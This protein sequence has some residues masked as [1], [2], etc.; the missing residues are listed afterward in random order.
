MEQK[1]NHPE[2]VEVWI[3]YFFKWGIPPRER[4]VSLSWNEF[5]QLTL[6]KPCSFPVR[7]I[8][9]VERV[10]S[11]RFDGTVFPDKVNA[12]LA[13]KLVGIEVDVLPKYIHVIR[14]K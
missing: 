3:S 6:G 5:D 1:H 11:Q 4:I 2:T 12:D 8:S 10:R 13:R 9:D 14:L 7:T